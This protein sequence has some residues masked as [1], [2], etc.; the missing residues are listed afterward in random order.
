MLTSI[1]LEIPSG[2]I[3]ALMSLYNHSGPLSFH[4]ATSK[5][6]TTHILQLA[7]W[8]NIS[9]PSLPVSS[10]KIMKSWDRLLPAA[11][12]HW[13][14]ESDNKRVWVIRKLSSDRK[15]RSS[16]QTSSGRVFLSRSVR[17]LFENK[18]Q[19]DK[20]RNLINLISL[21]FHQR[22]AVWWR[23]LFKFAKIQTEESVRVHTFFKYPT[24]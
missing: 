23:I 21:L 17:Q 5:Y 4:R 20:C 7:A 19:L 18:M 15:K 9:T 12:S 6:P 3:L 24:N 13:D 10:A 1:I 14:P 11:T 16:L 2:Q 22:Q 8:V